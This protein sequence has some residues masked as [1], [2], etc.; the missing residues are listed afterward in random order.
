MHDFAAALSS[1][2]DLAHGMRKL[3]RFRAAFEDDARRLGARHGWRY[4]IDEQALAR[5]FFDW[6]DAIGGEADGARANRAGFTLFCGGLALAGLVRDAPARAH[7]TGAPAPDPG[8]EIA[9]D[10]IARFWPEG[11]LYVDFCIGVVS[12]VFEQEFGAPP[13]LDPCLDDLRT[14]WSFRENVTEDPALAAGFLDRFFGRE[15]DWTFPGR[16]AM[17]SDAAI[18]DGRDTA[19]KAIADD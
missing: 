2:P 18:E 13:P 16:L 14:W 12:A 15:P 9:A 3:G 19:G 6:I 11:F 5:M 4:D 1:T 17:R 7:R 8:R 10:R